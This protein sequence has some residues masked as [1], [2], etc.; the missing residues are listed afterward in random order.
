M[1]DAGL[2]HLANL[3]K[4]EDLDLSECSLITDQGPA[5][6]ANKKELKSSTSALAITDAGGAHWP[7]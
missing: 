1:S 5:H 7:G 3:S 6:L 2:A 4:L